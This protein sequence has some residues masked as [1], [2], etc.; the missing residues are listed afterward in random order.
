MKAKTTRYQKNNF[1]R[2]LNVKLTLF[3]ISIIANLTAED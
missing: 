3:I 1:D 2:L